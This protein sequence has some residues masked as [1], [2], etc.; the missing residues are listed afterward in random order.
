QTME[1]IT[2]MAWV[3]GFADGPPLIPRGACDPFA[4][5][6]AVLALLTALE[7]RDH[8]GEGML[9]EVTMVEAA[10]NA[11]AEQVVEHAANGTLSGRRRLA[12]GPRPT[13]VP[14]GAAPATRAR[15]PDGSS[16]RPRTP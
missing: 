3:T 7:A 11:A 12:T 6:H 5:M 2:G 1:Q 14:P 8:T 13:C 16:K 9:V 15:G 10:L 4:G